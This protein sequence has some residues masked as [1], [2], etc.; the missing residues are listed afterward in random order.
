MCQRFGMREEITM[1]PNTLPFLD[2]ENSVIILPVSLFC[3]SNL[4]EY[5]MVKMTSRDKKCSVKCE[6]GCSPNIIILSCVYWHS[7]GWRIMFW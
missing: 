2:I 5:K 1:T 7:F 3:L 4:Y 6:S